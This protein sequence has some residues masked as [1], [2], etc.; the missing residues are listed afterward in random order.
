MG[1]FVTTAKLR[2]TDTDQRVQTETRI[3][4]VTVGIV[5]ENRVSFPS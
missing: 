4:P 2:L 1:L 5:E 3:V